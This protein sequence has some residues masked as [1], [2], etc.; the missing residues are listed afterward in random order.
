[1]NAPADY[2]GPHEV[3][4]KGSALARWLLGCAG[5][6]LQYEGF[7]SL[8]GVAI[9][10]PHTSNWDFVVM[11]LAKWTIGVPAHFW[12]KD[13]LFRVP[14]LGR[15]LSWLGGIAL[16]RGSPQGMVGNMVNL[17]NQHRQEG[18]VLWLALS[19]EG[20]RRR[21]PGWR[22]GFYRV[23]LG[24]DVPVALVHLDYSRKQVK[25][26]DF[27][28]MSGDID[29]DHARIAAAYEGVGGLRPEGASPV[30]PLSKAFSADTV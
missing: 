10:Y 9:I 8:Q 28:R 16:Q 19:P 11:I 23:A 22:S 21:M 14:L 24:A 5:W 3:R 4:F 30:Q 29:A 26:M 12:S 25:V 27:L 13:S 18:R 1:M 17:M 20:T 15:W 2:P 7:P 6:K